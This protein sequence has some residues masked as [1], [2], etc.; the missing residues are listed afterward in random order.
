VL[1]GVYD[2]GDTALFQKYYDDVTFLILSCEGYTTCDILLK[3]CLS[4]L[5]IICE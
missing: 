2:D 1:S 4:A 5:R 3:I